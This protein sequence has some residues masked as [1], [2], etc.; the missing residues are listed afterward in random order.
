MEATD[1]LIVEVPVP[2][3]EAGEKPTVIPDGC[4]EAE[5]ETAELKP[6]VTVLVIVLEPP[7]PPEVRESD[8]GEAERLKP[9]AGGPVRAVMRAAVGLPH[10]VTR[11]KPVTAE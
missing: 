5:R 1:T 2:V 10:P 9:A 7:A 8:V 3:I 6:P 11:S 4:P